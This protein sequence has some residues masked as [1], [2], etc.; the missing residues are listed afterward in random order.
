MVL[1]SF[2]AVLGHLLEG[3]VGVTNCLALLGS[4]KDEYESKRLRVPVC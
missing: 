2:W 4:D 1:G 3:C